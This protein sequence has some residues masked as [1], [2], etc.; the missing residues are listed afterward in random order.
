MWHH[1]KEKPNVMEFD[2]RVFSAKNIK[3]QKMTYISYKS[4]IFIKKYIFP[5]A[6]RWSCKKVIFKVFIFEGTPRP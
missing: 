6:K 1:V 3:K 5:I 4:I 2:L